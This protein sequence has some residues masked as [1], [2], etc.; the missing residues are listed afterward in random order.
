MKITNQDR[1]I[2]MKQY[3]GMKYSQMFEERH[4]NVQN[5]LRNFK[6]DKYPGQ[7]DERNNT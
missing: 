4:Q 6:S 2:M 5:Q 3:N 1:M 7:Y